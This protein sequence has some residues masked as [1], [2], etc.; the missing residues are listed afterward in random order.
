MSESSERRAERLRSL[1]ETVLVVSSRLS[2]EEV[3]QEL[4][5][6]ARR[7][8]GCERVVVTSQVEGLT[9]ET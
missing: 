5:E 8:L 9:V 6:N 4:A 1:V 2:E 3:L 7:V